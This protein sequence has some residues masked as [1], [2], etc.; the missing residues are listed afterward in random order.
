METIDRRKFCKG[1]AG[2]AG[3]KPWVGYKSTAGG[4][5]FTNLF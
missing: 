1:A 3:G 5:W 2:L 4:N